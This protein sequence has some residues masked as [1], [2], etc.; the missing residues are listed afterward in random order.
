M[1]EL[2]GSIPKLAILK[3]IARLYIGGFHEHMHAL[4]CR[5]KMSQY[6]IPGAVL[7][8]A[9]APES[10]FHFLRLFHNLFNKMGAMFMPSVEVL[11][12]VTNTRYQAGLPNQATAKS[13]HAF[14][15]F[16]SIH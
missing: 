10:Y 13:L 6:T 16:V 11:L 15:H 5:L 7:D 3:D 9:D 14:S 1:D 8:L 4:E 2:Y 12:S